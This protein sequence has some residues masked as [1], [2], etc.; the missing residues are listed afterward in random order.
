MAR[1]GFEMKAAVVGNKL[2]G[3]MKGGLYENLVACM[4]A[5]NGV[6]LHYWMSASGSQ[7]VEFLVDW[8]A[9]VVPVEVKASRGSTASLD[10]LLQ[11]ED[12]KLDNKLIDGNAGAGGKKTTL[13]LY[14]AP[15]L[16]RRT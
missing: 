13:P 11:R 6:P 7:E 1:Y 4:L 12:V 10:C 8:D 9:S 15:F 14:L 16:F 5:C 2:K 3:P